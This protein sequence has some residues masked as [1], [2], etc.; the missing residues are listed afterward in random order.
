MPSRAPS[1]CRRCGS[2]RKLTRMRRQRRRVQAQ[3][4]D[5]GQHRAQV[6]AIV[7]ARQ[8]QAAGIHHPV[9]PRYSSSSRRC[10]P[11]SSSNQMHLA[12]TAATS[13]AARRGSAA[14][15]TATRG[16]ASVS[17][18]QLVLEVARLAC[19]ASPGV[20]ERGS[21][22]PRLPDAAPH[23]RGLVA[24]QFDHPE[25]GAGSTSSSSSSGR[26]MLPAS[27]VRWPAARS[28]CAIS[29]VVVLLPLVPVT[30]IVRASRVLGE[31]QRGAADEARAAAAPRR[32]AGECTG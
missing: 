7:P 15:S 19:R 5:R 25:L 14:L 32:R 30:Q 11:S 31:P 1:V 21:A 17:K 9:S 4:L 10:Q 12:A 27:A 28:R 22:R 8:R 3:R 23:S 6:D 29:A 13:N 2:G 26:P 16:C 20:R 18:R 24:G